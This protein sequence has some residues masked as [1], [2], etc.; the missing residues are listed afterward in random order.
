MAEVE[1]ELKITDSKSQF[2]YETLKRGNYTLDEFQVFYA[3]LKL[4][5]PEANTVFQT[6][7]I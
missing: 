6:W 7:F 4:Q 1:L 3:S 2:H 5:C